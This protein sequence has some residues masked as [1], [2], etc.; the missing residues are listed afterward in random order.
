MRCPWSPEPPPVQPDPGPS[1]ALVGSPKPRHLV[2]ASPAPRLAPDT[3]VLPSC[4]TSLP[5]CPGSCLPTSTAVHG[6]L[7]FCSLTHTIP[8]S[9][10]LVPCSLSSRPTVFAEHILGAKPCEQ[11]AQPPCPSASAVQRG[12]CGLVAPGTSWSP[13]PSVSCPSSPLPSTPTMPQSLPLFL[14]Q[15]LGPEDPAVRGQGGR[16]CRAW[17]CKDETGIHPEEL[18]TSLGREPQLHWGSGGCRG[19][20]WGWGWS[21]VVVRRRRGQALE[22]GWQPGTRSGPPDTGPLPQDCRRAQVSVEV[23]V[24]PHLGSACA[25]GTLTFPTVAPASASGPAAPLIHSCTSALIP[26][27]SASLSPPLLPP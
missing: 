4:P 24:S 15:S 5:P 10:C 22:L 6:S 25:S 8:L 21:G 11:D 17:G 9:P 14:T 27:F 1:L 3:G 2:P 16:W 18:R 7:P 13:L 19:W 12:S 26:Q 23:A 20:S